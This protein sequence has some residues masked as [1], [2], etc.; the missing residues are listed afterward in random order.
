MSEKL[1]V[2]GV[3]GGIDATSVEDAID[4]ALRAGL[5]DHIKAYWASDVLQARA[6]RDYALKRVFPHQRGTFLAEAQVSAREGAFH[7]QYEQAVA[8]G[9]PETAAHFKQW[10]ET[11]PEPPP[12]ERG[13]VLQDEDI[14]VSA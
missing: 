12:P 14:R 2:A 6:I 4:Q 1:M 3:H 8:E 11:Y 10:V 9:N 13:D 7:R 5:E